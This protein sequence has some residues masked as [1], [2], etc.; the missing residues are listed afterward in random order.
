MLKQIPSY[1]ILTTKT[2]SSGCFRKRRKFRKKF[3]V[4]PKLVRRHIQQTQTYPLNRVWN[5]GQW[6]NNYWIKNLNRTLK[7]SNG[8]SIVSESKISYC[9][10]QKF[11]CI[12]NLF[13]FM[14]SDSNFS[15]PLEIIRGTLSCDK[16]E[17]IQH[18]NFFKIFR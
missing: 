18:V 11:K 14:N 12:F 3:W 4:V 8:I 16:Y 17:Q 10:F 9:W 5:C 7:F 1:Q 13:S 2:P 6:Q 15:N